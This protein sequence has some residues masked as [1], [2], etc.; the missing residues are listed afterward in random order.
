MAAHE[1]DRPP[2]CAGSPNNKAKVAMTKSYGACAYGSRDT[3]PQRE[4]THDFF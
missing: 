1:E 4:S 2:G 3:L